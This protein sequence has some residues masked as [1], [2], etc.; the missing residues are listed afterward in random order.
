[1]LGLGSIISLFGFLFV[2]SVFHSSVFFF[3]PSYE[4]LEHFLEFYFY[5][6][7]VYVSGFVYMAI[8][9][10]LWVLY[11]IITYNCLLILTFSLFT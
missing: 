2:L 5:L 9:V 1:M 8:L 10:V 11:Y 4:L 7:I 3:L 6:C